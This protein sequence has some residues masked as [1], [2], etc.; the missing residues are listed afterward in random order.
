MGPSA[1][2]TR[3]RQ[4][5]AMRRTRSTSPPKSWWPGVSMMLIFV[6]LYVTEVFLARIVMPR[7]RSRSLESMTQSVTSW[8]ARKA[9]DCRS[10][11]ST[12]VVFPWSTCA[13]MAILRRSIRAAEYISAMGGLQPRLTALLI[14]RRRQDFLEVELDATPGLQGRFRPTDAEDGIRQRRG[15]EHAVLQKLLL[16][17]AGQPEQEIIAD[18]PQLHAAVGGLIVEHGR[19]LVGEVRHEARQDL[20]PPREVGG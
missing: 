1:A 16:F 17:Q 19:R 2:S 14:F 13:M 8:L 3:S 20:R 7:S 18:I 6:P 15:N 10:R 4:P 9:P 11:K 5:S 12:R